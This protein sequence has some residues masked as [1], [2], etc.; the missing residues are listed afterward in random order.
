MTNAMKATMGCVPDMS[1]LRTGARGFRAASSCSWPKIRTGEPVTRHF[2]RN[3]PK[4][5]FVVLMNPTTIEEE[6]E[7]YAHRDVMENGTKLTELQA[8]LNDFRNV[9]ACRPLDHRTYT[10]MFELSSFLKESE[11]WRYNHGI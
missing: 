3:E 9:K 2:T 7:F 8:L 1:A 11:L 10:T 4:V 5:G 6:E